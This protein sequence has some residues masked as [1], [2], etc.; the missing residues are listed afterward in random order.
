MAANGGFATLGFLYQ[1]VDVSS[2]KTKTP[3]KS[4]NRIV[5]DDRFFFKIKP[6]LWALKSHKDSV[7]KLFEIQKPSNEADSSFT[8]AYFQGLLL[9]VGN[10]RG[11]QTFVPNQDKRKFFLSQHLGAVASIDRIYDFSYDHFVQ[12]ARNIDVTW[13]NSRRMPSS[14]FEVEH[15]TDI[16]NS[17]IK[18]AEL[19]DFYAD[20]CIVADFARKREFEHKLGFSVFDEVKARV[21]FMSY[22]QLSELHTNTYKLNKTTRELDFLSRK[23]H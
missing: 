2:W 8:H 4:I 3:F 17:L 19:S 15:S 22:D 10:M 12:R 20:F 14:F 5:Q 1:T 23:P 13:F 11:F 9:E 21:S 6:G 7:L 16:F 18:F